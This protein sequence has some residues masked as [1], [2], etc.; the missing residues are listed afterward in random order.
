MI[1][2]TYTEIMLQEKYKGKYFIKG[3]IT[4]PCEADLNWIEIQI[5][6]IDLSKKNIYDRPIGIVIFTKFIDSTNPET[7][8]NLIFK[9]LTQIDPL[10][11]DGNNLMKDLCSK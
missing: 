1:S 5:E 8:W 10:A 7:L 6:L 11:I 2:F 3:V 4:R 9:E